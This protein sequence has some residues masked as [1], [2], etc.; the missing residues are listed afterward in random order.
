MQPF[1]HHLVVS[2]QFGMAQPPGSPFRLESFSDELP[3]GC[4]CLFFGLLNVL[5]G[6][7]EREVRATYHLCLGL[8]LRG[9][10]VGFE[11]G[12]C[13]R[14]FLGW[15]KGR[16]DK[17]HCLDL[18]VV[19]MNVWQGGGRE[20]TLSR[21]R[22]KSRTELMKNNNGHCLILLRHVERQWIEEGHCLLESLVLVQTRLAGSVQ[23]QRHSA[24]VCLDVQSVRPNNT[25]SGRASRRQ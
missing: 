20:K 5:S 2:G 7:R 13:R 14:G 22:Q 16:H 19:R 3:G 4:D 11:P 23:Q 1:K 9:I 18:V 24:S 25:R 6:R 15:R 10:I 17:R 21:G 8:F 12:D